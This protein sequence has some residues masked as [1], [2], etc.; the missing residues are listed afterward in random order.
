[1]LRHAARRGD[2]PGDELRRMKTM[3]ATYLIIIA[4]GLIAS[5]WSAAVHG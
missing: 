3:F 2:R 4:L 5:Y 1:V